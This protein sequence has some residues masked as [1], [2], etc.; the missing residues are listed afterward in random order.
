MRITRREFL[1]YC[2]IAAGALGLSAGTMMKLEEALALEAADGG[3]PVMWLEGAACTGCTMSLTN[4][5]YYGSVA[6]VLLDTLDLDFH[7]TVMVACG[8]EVDG[9]RFT[10]ANALTAANDLYNSGGYVLVVE[11]AIQTAANGE[12]CECGDLIGDHNETM[13]NL[14]LKMADKAYVIICVGQCATYGGIPAAR[15]NV[16][17]AKG[18]WDF[19]GSLTNDQMTALGATTAAQRRALKR[20]L[21][22]KVINVPGCPPHPD[23][24]VGTIAEVLARNPDLPATP[25]MPA[26]DSVR[27]PALFFSGVHCFSCDR[28]PGQQT[29]SY[30][31]GTLVQTEADKTSK[32]LKNIG[33]KGRVTKTDCPV[34]WWNAE[35]GAEKGK[36]YCVAAGFPCHG[37]T[38]PGFPDKHSPFI[39][40][41]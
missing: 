2:S 15:G 12:F 37:C 5:I 27:R 14:A 4:S 38:Q 35:S 25:R 13:A 32:C 28:Y 22:K 9:T 39:R 34:R 7:K 3:I 26:L 40:I 29:G 33:C 17:G 31:K 8:A 16:T 19:V 41:P 21:Q 20:R 10:G 1:K 30:L 24:I 11:G 18:M 23:W 36:N 6:D